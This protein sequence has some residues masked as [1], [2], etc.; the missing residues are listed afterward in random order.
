MDAAIKP[1][2]SMPVQFEIDDQDLRCFE[3]GGHNPG[4]MTLCKA[5]MTVPVL[6]QQQ[7]LFG[8]NPQQLRSVPAAKLCLTALCPSHCQLAGTRSE[9]NHSII[10][11]YISPCVKSRPPGFQDQTG[12]TLW[13][14][15]EFTDLLIKCDGREVMRAHR[16]I[17]AAASPAL[18]AML[19][20][21]MVEAR[22]QCIEFRDAEPK[23]V[24][25]MLQFIYTGAVPDNIDAKSVVKL[26]HMY[27]LQH[28]VE[29]C[30][31]AL[32]ENLGPE[33]VLD[34]VRVLRGYD[35][36]AVIQDAY[37][38]VCDRFAADRALQTAVLSSV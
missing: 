32:L 8:N 1:S 7:G 11:Q 30:C 29:L 24:E 3:C 17:L 2:V 15:R 22:E 13:Q 38:V 6:H 23:D 34:T 10:V 19:R 33:N 9:S 18:S 4:K 28:L 5:W 31:A 12:S 16:C 14:Q 27:G 20:S 37:K 26:A 36:N 35:D 25:A 21:D